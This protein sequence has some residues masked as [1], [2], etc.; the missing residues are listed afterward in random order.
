MVNFLKEQKGNKPGPRSDPK[1]VFDLSSQAC[2]FMEE[3][4]DKP[5]FIYLA[6]HAPHGPVNSRNS[7]REKIN[8]PYEACVYD[9]DESVNRV[10]DKIKDLGIEK[11]TL[12]IYT[13]DNGGCVKI[14][15]P[16]EEKR[17]CTTKVGFVYP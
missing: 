14:K 15:N 16:L 4:K 2:D 1:G 11:K 12:I 10:L 8:N 7:T 13:S 17:E 3:N 5:F 6:H 9:L